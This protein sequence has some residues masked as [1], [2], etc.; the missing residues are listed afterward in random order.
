MGPFHRSS[1]ESW[2]TLQYVT[3]GPKTPPR[4][5]IRGPDPSLYTGDPISDLDGGPR[6]RDHDGVDG[7]AHSDCGAYERENIAL[8]VGE[9]LNLAWTDPMTLTWDG[10]PSAVAYH[11]YRDD[12]ENSRDLLDHNPP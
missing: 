3:I 5:P 4:L 2:F 10:E 6:L 8:P 9:V 12:V 1:E 11:V 7:L